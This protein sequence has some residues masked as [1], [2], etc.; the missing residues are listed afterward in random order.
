MR[1][2]KNMFTAM[3]KNFARRILRNEIDTR[4]DAEIKINHAVGMAHDELVKVLNN[5]KAT[6]AQMVEAM[7]KAAAQLNEAYTSII[8]H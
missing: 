7:E 1:K 5:K 6:K 3:L 8:F 2:I 4:C